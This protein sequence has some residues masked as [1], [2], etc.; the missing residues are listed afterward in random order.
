M[1]VQTEVYLESLDRMEVLSGPTGR[2]RWPDEVKG[3]L[4]SES[5]VPGVSVRDVALRNGLPPNR[6]SAWRSQAKRGDLV[7]PDFTVP[8]IMGSDQVVDEVAGCDFASI[9]VDDPAPVP[10]GLCPIEV[11]TGDVTVRLDAATD[12]RHLAELVLALKTGL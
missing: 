9:V 1:D 6:L 12:V 3:R 8:D 5:L 7:I 2:R 10:M 4:V 11:E